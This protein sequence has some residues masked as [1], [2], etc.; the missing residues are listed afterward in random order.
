MNGFLNSKKHVPPVLDQSSLTPLILIFGFL[1]VFAQD[2]L[3]LTCTSNAT[4][5]WTTNATWTGCGGNA[6]GAGDTAIIASPHVVT[7]NNNATAGAVTVNVGGT[8]LVPGANFAVNGATNVSGTLSHTNTGGNENYNGLVTINAG[9]VWD[10]AVGEN[11]NFRGGLTHNGTTFT[12]G[13]GRMDFRTNNQAIGGTSPITFS[14]AD[15]IRV[16]DGITLTN[17]TNVTIST[18]LLYGDNAAST[19][20]NAAN[21]TLNYANVTAPMT[22]GTL[23][24]F[25]AS[26]VGNTVNYNGAAQTVRLPTASTYYHLTL[27]GSGAKTLPAAA[28]A[29]NGNFTISGTATTTAAGAL[30]VGG[31]FTVGAGTTFAASTFA[32]SV[33]GNF[34]N[35]G[36]FTANTSTFT[37]NGA[38]AQSLTGATTFNNMTMNNATGLTINNNVTVSSVLNL[39]SGNITTGTNILI[40]TP[41]CNTAG[42]VARSSGHVLGNLRKTVPLGTPITCTWEVGGATNYAP[43]TSTFASVTTAGTLTVR[44]DDGDHADT[45]AGT[46]GIGGSCSIN[47]RWTLTPA[48][49]VVSTYSP[50][51]T[52]VNPGDLDSGV[53][54]TSTNFIVRKK[55]AGTWILPTTGTRTATS[56]QATGITNAQGFGEFALGYTSATCF[57]HFAIAHSGSAVNCQAEDITIAVHDVTHAIATSYIG[58]ITLSTSTGKGDWSIV[59]GSGTLD[60]GTANDGAATYTFVAADNGDVVLGLKDTV[61]EIVNINVTNGTITEASGTATVAE[62]ANLTFAASGFRITDGG[63]PPVAASIATQTAGVASATYGLQAIRTDTSTGA[64]VGAFASGTDVTIDLA[65]QCNN[66]IACIAGQ[67]V[68]MTNNAVTANIASNPNSGVVSYTARSLRFGANSQALF[69]LNYPDAGS[70]SLHARYNIPLGSGGP[71]STNMLGSSNTFVVKPYGFVL[72]NIQATTLAGRCT[73]NPDSIPACASNATG[74]LF[75]KAGENFSATVTAIQFNGSATPNYGQETSPEGVTLTHALVAPGGGASGTLANSAAFGV[76]S[77]GAATGTTFNW[78]EVGIITL[79]PSVADGDYLGVGNTTGSTSG[80]VG[81]FYP[82]H[83]IVTLPALTNRVLSACA[84]V[85]TFTYAGEQM[86]T[87]FTL[88]ARN[89]LAVPATTLN[90]TTANSFAKLDGAVPANFGF[91]AI[92]LADAV[93]PL[94]ASALTPSL[95]LVS[96]SGIWA[97][98]EA[99]FTARLSLIRAATPDGPYESFRLGILPVDSD[100]VTL[101]AVDLDLDTTV[102]ADSN[103]QVRVGSS[104]VRFG[105]LKLSNAHGSELLNLPIP[106]ETQ[107]WNGTSFVRND[108]DNCTSLAPA[109]FTLDAYQGGITAVNL[110]TPAGSHISIGGAFVA[111]RGTLKLTKPNPTPTATGSANL[112]VDLVAASK[113]Y[114]QGAWTGAAYNQNPVSHATF[115][116]FKGS[117]NIIYQRENY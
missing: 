55:N 99:A 44:T 75:A 97:S 73:V 60:N 17:N 1:T 27:S 96:S 64:C 29:V 45:T 28:M 68:A 26:A 65:S 21:S 112:T 90:Y 6:P 80:N 71:S 78:S 91:G 107:Y 24:G 7:V 84:P 103:D 115:G 34:S 67:N 31:N 82:D 53:D 30:T 87:N 22:S 38:A 18:G 15:A 52:F 76:F 2:S 86:Q 20:V 3:A 70:I 42:A 13:T 48:T 98:G 12:T 43:V 94:T 111:G 49:L 77:G 92:D 83:F 46:S 14:G 109:N 16:R 81:R 32:H 63:A 8:L 11:I 72:S 40:M 41:N 51:F 69:T 66:P 10:N 9:G 5:N 54:P 85:A 114:L 88:T 35:S 108:V 79:T 50:T 39:S 95:A 37:F 19:W 116:V 106:I 59:T 25:T 47:R 23:G 58:T 61:A 100:G 62:D 105:R 33:A 117:N 102:P 113:T 36:T 89:G 93:A 57:N 56:T 74:A 101:R 110:D 4:G 104:M